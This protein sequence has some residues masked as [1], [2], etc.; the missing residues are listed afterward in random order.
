MDD[1]VTR[2][3][4]L[5]ERTLLLELEGGCTIPLA[6]WARDGD[7][8]LLLDAAVFDLDGQEKI[9]VSV[10]GPIDDPQGL[11]LHAANR[12]RELGAEAILARVRS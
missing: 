2:R 11:G 5:A 9:V 1:A 6:A 10:S 8:V 3:A 7:G 4:V 12:L